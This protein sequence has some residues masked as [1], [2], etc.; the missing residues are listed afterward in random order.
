MVKV[1]VQIDI[2]SLP[3]PKTSIRFYRSFAEKAISKIAPEG[4]RC[5]AG[6]FL[7]H[8]P[9]PEIDRDAGF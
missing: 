5:L 4:H 1:S 6:R 3:V 9:C 2:N 8:G 7:K